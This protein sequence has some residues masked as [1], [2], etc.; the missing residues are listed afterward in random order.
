MRKLRA[1]AASVLLLAGCAAAGSTSA[2]AATP[3]GD[4]ASR[5][6]DEQI[7]ALLYP[8]RKSEAGRLFWEPTEGEIKRAKLDPIAGQFID[9][10]LTI[11]VVQVEPIVQSGQA[12]LLAITSAH[13]ESGCHACTALAGVAVLVS[14]SGAWRLEAKDRTADV[15]G[16]YGLFPKGKLV[17]IGPQRYAVLIL[18]TFGNEG[19]YATA[20][21]LLG[22]TDSGVGSLLSP[23]LDIVGADNE[24][25]DDCAGNDD[26]RTS[27]NGEVRPRLCYKYDSEFLFEPV[28]GRAYHEL[29]VH[30]RGTR[31]E[32]ER[33]DRSAPVDEI[34][35]FRFSKG[36]YR[37]L[38]GDEGA[39]T[40]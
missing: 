23:E 8:D 21:T 35:R 36:R 14:K 37:E 19:D 5:P 40:R 33:I 16:Q 2:S 6:S 7:V 24:A 34:R 29:K 1:A 39:L 26:A 25:S 27:A 9:A 22:Q 11:S 12:K 15:V 28:P 3:Q 20:A 4:P 17:R 13:G 31:L 38:K 18:T 10:Q 32:T 30:T